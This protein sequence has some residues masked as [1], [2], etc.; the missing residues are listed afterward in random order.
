MAPAV[1]RA[2]EVAEMFSLS[3][4]AV[5]EAVKR[6]EAPIGTAAIRCGRRVV[7]PKTS[8]DRLLGLQPQ[9]SEAT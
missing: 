5:Y 4:W 7:W 6:Q 3:P 2:E 9:S 1:Y 8:I